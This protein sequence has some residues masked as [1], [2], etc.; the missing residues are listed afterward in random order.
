V[1]VIGNPDWKPSL[2]GLAASSLSDDHKCSV[3]IW[4]RD[5]NNILKGSCRSDGS[6]SLVDLMSEV[7]KDILLDFGGHTM[8][9]GFSVSAEK[10]HLLEDRLQIAYEKVILTSTASLELDTNKVEADTKITLD[11]VTLENYKMI[12][13][14][15]PYGVGNPK[16]LFLLEKVEIKN[17]KK[18]GKE[19]NHL[20]LSFYNSRERTVKAIGFFMADLVE[21]KKLDIKQKINL[22]AN[23]E[24]ST[25]AGRT[26]L[27][28][29]IV[30][31]EIVL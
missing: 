9:G 29:R 3:F 13:K 17:I 28:L 24:N 18:F 6:V 7:E 2:V 20:E 10:V 14:L 21:K 31:L 15:A 27:R 11:E 4:G 1:I 23:F 5:G 26:E 8:A 22:L 19:A 30:D 12:A 16:P 25:F